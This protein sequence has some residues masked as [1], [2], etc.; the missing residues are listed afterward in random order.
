MASESKNGAEEGK[1]C[2]NIHSS[3]TMLMSK[4]DGNSRFG[5][6]QMFIE[7]KPFFSCKGLFLGVIMPFQQITPVP[8]TLHLSVVPGSDFPLW[9]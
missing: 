7:V 9:G 2:L 4:R 8:F 6:A 5:S 1:P 3:D